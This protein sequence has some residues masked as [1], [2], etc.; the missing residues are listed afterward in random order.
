MR[1]LENYARPGDVVM[2]LSVSGNSK[3]L[4]KAFDWCKQNDVYTIALTGGKKGELVKLADHSIAIN[5]THYG[6]VEDCQM[7]ICHMICYAFIELKELY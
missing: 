6:R 4:I 3:N 5:S 2:T 1:Q 7:H